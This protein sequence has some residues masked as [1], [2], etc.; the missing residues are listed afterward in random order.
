[1]FGDGDLTLRTLK[2][3]STLEIS[4]VLL[5]LLMYY[6]LL[7]IPGETEHCLVTDILSNMCSHKQYKETYHCLD[8]AS[9]EAKWKR[10]QRETGISHMC[11]FSLLLY[12]DMAWSVPHGFMHA[13]Y[14]NQFK[15]LIKLWWGKF[16]GLNNGNGNFIIS[17]LIWCIIR[18]ETR[19]AVQTI[20][21]GFIHSIPNIDLD[22][23]SF[24][25]EDSGFWLTWPPWTIL[26]APPDSD[27]GH[28]DLYR[29]W[30][31]TRRTQ[32]LKYDVISVALG[33]WRIILPIWPKATLCHDTY[34]PC[35]RSPTGWHP[36]HQT[37]YSAVGVHYR[38]EHGRGHVECDIVHV[39]ILAAH[40]HPPTV[41]ATQGDEDEVS[42]HEG[43]PGLHQRTPWLECHQQRRE[44]FSW[45]WQS[46]HPPDSTWLVQAHAH[47]EGCNRSVLQEPA[48][49]CSIIKLIAKYI[50]NKVEWWGKICF[51]CDTEC[52]QSHW[53]HDLVRG[54]HR[55]A[56]FARVSLWILHSIVNW[57]TNKLKLVIDEYEDDLGRPAWDMRTVC[58]SQVQS[59]I[60]VTLPAEL[61]LKTGTN[62]TALLALVMLCKMNRKDA[63]MEPVWYQEMET[64]WAFDIVTID[65]VIGQI[66]VSN[67][68]GI[69]DW[70]YR[71]QRAVMHGLLEPEYKSEEDN[72]W[73]IFYLYFTSALA[74]VT[75]VI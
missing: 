25:A 33:L 30:H 7:T 27:Q 48:G 56:S 63:S 29:L 20:P 2:L 58:Y 73:I 40:E 39:P 44:M 35:P 31:D 12:F 1:M 43:R 34:K 66:K 6:I 4:G 37:T 15:A 65:C 5:E 55:D 75:W 47:W 22:F 62:S 69:I 14:I 67:C 74:S 49:S 57:L 23:N 19:H 50:P 11:V 52:V 8:V 61:C 36:Q 64:V 46:N 72:D 10:I 42:G 21:S 13:M 54:T 38:E 17:S 32:G 51:K 59:Y 41:W 3:W 18:V 24:T 68:W 60:H 9:N 45:C 71:S 53:V 16:K 28:Q 70:S 26:L